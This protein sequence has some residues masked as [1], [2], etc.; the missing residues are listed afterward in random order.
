MLEKII[1]IIFFVSKDTLKIEPPKIYVSNFYYS[2]II[3]NEIY[4]NIKQ[5]FKYVLFQAL[6]ELRHHYQLLY[7]MNNTDSK[8]LRWKEEFN[9]YNKSNYKNLTIEIDAYKF[10]YKTIKSLGIKYPLSKEVKEVIKKWKLD[11]SYLHFFMD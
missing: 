2:F 9:N 3:N 10:A 4:I 8:S 5:E 7:I 1:D 6:H 11:N